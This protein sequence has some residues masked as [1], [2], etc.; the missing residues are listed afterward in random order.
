MHWKL[1]Q[2]HPGFIKELVQNSHLI[3][4]STLNYTELVT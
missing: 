3:A 1:V 2:P 4:L